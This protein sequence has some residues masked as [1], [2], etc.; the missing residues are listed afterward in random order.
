MTIREDETP[1]RRSS[2]EAVDRS[3]AE[4]AAR[5][6]E[7]HEGDCPAAATMM[8]EL[9]MT[10][11]ALYRRLMDRLVGQACYEAVTRVVRARR[12]IVWRTPRKA[13][14]TQRQ[15]SRVKAL[16]R[17][18]ALM[19]FPLPGGKPLGEA[20]AEEVAEAADA[21]LRTAADAGVKGRWLALV[22]DALGSSR[23]VV[24]AVLSEGTLWDL[25]RKAEQETV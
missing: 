8:E 10:D 12:G 22:R 21:Y 23:S 14:D 17:S 24:S 15:V 25:R 11:P 7:A 1:P 4:L 5:C 13:D 18:N 9:V 16:A 2:K 20:V 19:M 3:I 6:L